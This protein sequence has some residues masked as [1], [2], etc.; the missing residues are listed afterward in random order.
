MN[1]LFMAEAHLQGAMITPTLRGPPK[2]RTGL[3][4]SVNWITSETGPEIKAVRTFQM[5]S[6][7][8][9]PRLCLDYLRYRLCNPSNS[10][11]SIIVELA[12]LTKERLIGWIFARRINCVV[13][14]VVIV[15][16]V[17]KRIIF[18]PL[19]II[20]TVAKI[21]LTVVA[22]AT[23]TPVIAFVRIIYNYALL[24]LALIV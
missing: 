24:V 11:H 17:K 21:P 7:D 10:L 23:F 5:C 22:T 3:G 6:L 15:H 14:T 12:T 19:F 2:S 13:L 1:V 4:N 9:N 8:E 16:E 20:G 18:S